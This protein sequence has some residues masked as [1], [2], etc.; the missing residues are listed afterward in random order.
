MRLALNKK[1]ALW[2]VAIGAV[3]CFL[4]GYFVLGPLWS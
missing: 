1:E 2:V 3:P 4:F